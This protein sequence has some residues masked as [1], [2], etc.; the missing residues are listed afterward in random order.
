MLTTREHSHLA[1]GRA[2]RKNERAPSKQFAMWSGL[3]GALQ[4]L[5]Q[6]ARLT[7][8]HEARCSLGRAQRAWTWSRVHASRF[9]AM[10]LL[11]L[12]ARA[13]RVRHRLPV[14]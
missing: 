11:T 12:R 14:M 9:L 10:R 6:V 3:T 8:R 13:T 5:D 2:K 4:S 1:P 7:T